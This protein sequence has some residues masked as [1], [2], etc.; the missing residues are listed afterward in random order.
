M[1]C[2]I[3]P[4]IKGP[5]HMFIQHSRLIDCTKQLHQELYALGLITELRAIKMTKEQIK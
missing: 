3:S 1:I 2:E 5:F 4:K